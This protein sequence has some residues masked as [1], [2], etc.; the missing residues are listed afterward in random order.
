MPNP[1]NP[2]KWFWVVAGSTTE[3]YSSAAVAY[4]GVDNTT[5]QAWL[6]RGNEPTAIT[7]EQELIDVLT[8]AGVPLPAG[9]SASSSVKQKLT[10]NVNLVLLRILFNHENRIRTLQG[11][12]QITVAQFKNAIQ[13]LL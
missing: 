2:A 13:N 8:L 5:Y 7:T 4:V 9:K 1:Y 3:V 12:A 6:S 10:D 11:Q